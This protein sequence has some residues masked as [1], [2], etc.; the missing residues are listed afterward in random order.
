MKQLSKIDEEAVAKIAH[1]SVSTLLRLFEYYHDERIIG[2]DLL[3]IF[4]MW[5]NY[6]KC[7]SI[8]CKNYT[9]FALKIVKNYFYMTNTKRNTEMGGEDVAKTKKN[10]FRA[11]ENADKLLD[12]SILQHSL[13]I[14]CRLLKKTDPET[15]EH[16]ALI[17]I[18]PILLQISL[19]SEDVYLLLHTT[20]TLRTFIAVSHEKIQERKVTKKILEVAK[21]MLKPE[22]NESTAVFLGNFIIQIFSKI[23]PKIDT[24]ILMGVIEKIRKCRIPTI[25]QSLVLVYARLF[26][27]N[28]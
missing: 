8:F 21:K 9:P 19:E 7:K 1:E 18:F 15:E 2:P 25:V 26:H 3:E 17:D 6:E 28:K 24:D 13:D 23:S 12:S 4:K 16:A 5:T 11:L 27:T 20:S 10:E 14:L 22:T